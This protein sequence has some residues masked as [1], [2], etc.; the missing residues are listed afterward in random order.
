MDRSGSK[1]LPCPNDR[2]NFFASPGSFVAKSQTI[3]PDRSSCRTQDP[4]QPQSTQAVLVFPKVT[5]AGLMFGGQGGNG[6]LFLRDGRIGRFYQTAGISYGLQA[7]IQQ[8]GYPL[9]LTNNQAVTR[10]D[11]DG[12]GASA[13]RRVSWCSIREWP[14][15]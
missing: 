8:H 10:L 5:N 4:H 11:R 6:T 13:A 2:L 12:G 3:F 1:C 14:G 7:G 9:F 15:H